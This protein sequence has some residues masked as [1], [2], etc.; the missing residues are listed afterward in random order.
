VTFR[1]WV[2]PRARIQIRELITWW[3]ENRP[4]AA[5]H[6][7][8]ELQRVLRLLGDAPYVGRPYLPAGI[9]GVRRIRLKGTPYAVYYEVDDTAGMVNVGGVWSSMRGLGP[10]L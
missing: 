2:A 3:R 6:L 5:N 9:Q 1:L 8:R 7:P 10:P 4:A